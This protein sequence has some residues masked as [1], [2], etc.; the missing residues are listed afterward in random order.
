M[1]NNVKEGIL[2]KLKEKAPE[3]VSGAE[4]GKAFGVTRTSVWK[5]INQLKEEG[6]VIESSSKKGYKLESIPDI[7]NKREIIS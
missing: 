5:Y 3:Y 1:R 6:Y 2:L 4:L 7:L